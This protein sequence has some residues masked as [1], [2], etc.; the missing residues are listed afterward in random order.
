M[1][2]PYAKRLGRGVKL[3]CCASVGITLLASL[4]PF[5]PKFANAATVPRFLPETDVKVQYTL[6]VPGRAPHVYDLAYSAESERLRIDD[7]ARGLWFAADLRKAS[8]AVIVPELH[9]I[10]AAP[11]LSN[12]ATILQTVRTAR[13]TPVGEAT[14]AGLHCTRY[15]VVSER[16]SGTACLTPDGVALSVTG[17]DARGSAEAVA[18]SVTEAAVPAGFL[19][20]PANFSTITLPPSAIA[21]LLAQ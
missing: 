14:I 19:T 10:I 7:P 9:A 15:E 4:A 13:F 12:L 6:T 16:A 1:M 3:V 20:P 2:K 11:K 18:S 17:K 8:A 5:G 21:A